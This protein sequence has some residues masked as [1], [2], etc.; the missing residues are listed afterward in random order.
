MS[1]GPILDICLL[2]MVPTP[3]HRAFP[4]FPDGRVPANKHTTP[5]ATAGDTPGTPSKCPPRPFVALVVPSLSRATAPSHTTN[6]ASLP[7]LPTSTPTNSCLQP[8]SVSGLSLPL[9]RPPSLTKSPPPMAVETFPHS[10]DLEDSGR[11]ERKRREIGQVRPPQIC[12]RRPPAA[13]FT[14]LSGSHFRENVL[15]P[16]QRREEMTFTTLRRAAWQLRHFS[17]AI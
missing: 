3:A 6:K 13:T 4:G 16:R 1:A 2:P 5:L 14:A 10:A 11:V 17:F 9:P 8:Q 7:R 12:S 15:L